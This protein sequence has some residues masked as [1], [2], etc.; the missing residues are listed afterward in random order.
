[1]INDNK[2][3]YYNQLRIDLKVTDKMIFII[4]EDSVIFNH[5]IT[6]MGN[7]FQYG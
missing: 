4:K 5:K 6:E 2:L 3:I 1:M 7:L